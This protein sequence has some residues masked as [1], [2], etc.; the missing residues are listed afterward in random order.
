MDV[1]K[2]DARCNRLKLYPTKGFGLTTQKG[3]QEFTE[4]VDL[5]RIISTARW[6]I[7]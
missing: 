4:K 7:I 6:S 2:N 3:G 5:V 1:K